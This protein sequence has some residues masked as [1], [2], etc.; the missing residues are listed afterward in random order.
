MTGAMD[1]VLFEH[2]LDAADLAAL[3]R[4]VGIDLRHIAADHL[5][6][7]LPDGPVGAR[8]LALPLDGDQRHFVNITSDWIQLPHGD[9]HLLRSV[10]TE[11]PYDIPAGAR[12]G[13][14]VR[15]VGPCSWLGCDRYGRVDGIEIVSYE[16]EDD[17]L[18]AEGALLHREAV[19]YDRALRLR[20]ASGRV[21]TLTT[22]Y[23][24]ILGEIEIR[25]NDE[26]GP[27]EPHAR[28]RTRHILS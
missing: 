2:R 22:L 19:H 20:F 16:V 5:D 9:I 15:G 7:R 18:D 10:V 13:Q 4:L 11:T 23:P 26:I 12:D 17:V 27:T 21:L 6:L 1:P 25:T 8:S 14:G 28:V 3:A 24:S